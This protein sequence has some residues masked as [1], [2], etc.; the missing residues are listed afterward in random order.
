MGQVLNNMLLSCYTHKH[1][2]VILW[3]CEY[4]LSGLVG[5]LC[6]KFLVEG[7]AKVTWQQVV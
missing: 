7:G 5:E 6:G 2:S 4:S 1:D 3:R